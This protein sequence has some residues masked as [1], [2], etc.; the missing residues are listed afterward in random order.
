MQP[1]AWDTIRAGESGL[2]GRRVDPDHVANF[3]WAKDTDGRCALALIMAKGTT[4]NELRPTLNGIE[5]VETSDDSGDPA[6]LLVLRKQDDRELFQRLC[7]DI[8]A[9]CR[10]KPDDGAVL[11]TAIRRAWKWHSLLRGGLSSGLSREE[12]QGLIGE[13]I[14]FGM[15]AEKVGAGLAVAAW[16]GPFEEPKDFVFQQRAVEVKARHAT[17]DVVQI[18]SEHQLQ[19]QDGQDL[20]LFVAA[21]A[22]ATPGH[23]GAFTL[24]ELVHDVLTRCAASDPSCEAP[25]QSLI[26]RAGYSKEDDYSTDTWTLVA[27]YGY[28]VES[29]FPRVQHSDLPVGV[30][31]VKYALSLGDC[32]PFQVPVANILETP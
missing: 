5:L 11:D 4:S 17:K 20:F 2:T 27:T 25:L 24:E 18:S 10:D 28:A 31:S 7:E 19:I 22:P 8:V 26:K 15:L 3:F 32:A 6:F 9:A 29:G 12:Q 21:L 14:F 13:L 30:G 1:D 16:R 23:A